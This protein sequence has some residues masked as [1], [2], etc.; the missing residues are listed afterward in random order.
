MYPDT[1]GLCKLN[2]FV[3]NTS[4]PNFKVIEPGH[5]SSLIDGVLSD[6]LLSVIEQIQIVASR[7]FVGL[8]NKTIGSERCIRLDLLDGEEW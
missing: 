1:I 5:E 4:F 8:F 7:Q 2:Y 6:A 3:I